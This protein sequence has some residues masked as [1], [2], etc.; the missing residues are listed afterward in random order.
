MIQRDSP[1]NDKDNGTE[2][3]EPSCSRSGIDRR[4][5]TYS[6]HIPER[7]S[8]KDRRRGFDRRGGLGRRK[9]HDRRDR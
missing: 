1:M 6:Y 3:Q 7:R 4:Q 5:F 8:G 2:N 9:G